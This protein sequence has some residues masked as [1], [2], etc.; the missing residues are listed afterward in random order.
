MKR[1]LPVDRLFWL[2]LGFCMGLGFRPLRSQ[3]DMLQG[4]YGA[5]GGAG[6]A[7]GSVPMSSV[8][9]AA[10]TAPNSPGY[11]GQLAIDERYLYSFYGGV[12]R[13]S[14]RANLD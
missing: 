4:A 3:D 11:E 1:F 5:S 6:G 7:G 9:A 14:A 2:M 12:W 10:P 13:R 8:R